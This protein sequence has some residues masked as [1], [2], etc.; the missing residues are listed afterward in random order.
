MRDRFVI[1]S[2]LPDGKGAWML[3]IMVL[4]KGTAYSKICGSQFYIAATT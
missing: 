3:K 2:S 1:T 4:I